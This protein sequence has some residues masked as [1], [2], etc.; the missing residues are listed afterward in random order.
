LLGLIFLGISLLVVVSLMISAIDKAMHSNCKASC[1]YAIDSPTLPNPIDI[2]LR[3]LSNFFP[4]DLVFFTV[5]I[6]Y[7]FL[8]SVYGLTKIGI[9]VCIWK[10]YDVKERGTMANGLLFGCWLLMFIVLAV[11]MELLTLVPQYTTFGDQTYV[12]VLTGGNKTLECSLSQFKNSTASSNQCVMTQ[13][14]QF[15]NSTQLSLSVFGVLFYFANWAFLAAFIAFFLY[16][17]L[18]KKA[19]S[20]YEELAIPLNDDMDES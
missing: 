8:C 19:P 9:R 3:K 12:N 16:I 2:S 4:L 6:I 18:C 20:G 15:V 7:I 1:G 10:F 14:S 11:D 17:L 13:L 5:G